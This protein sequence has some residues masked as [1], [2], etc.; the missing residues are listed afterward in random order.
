MC[1]NAEKTLEEEAIE[2]K[3]GLMTNN[4]LAE[5]FGV[6]PRTFTNAKDK[7][8]EELK[9]YA[10]FEVLKGKINILKIKIPVYVK[11]KSKNYLIIKSHID[12]NWNDSGLDNKKNVAE[13]IFNKKEEYHLN[14]KYS[15][16]YSYTCKGSNELYGS[17]RE[18]DKG[19]EIGNCRYVLCTVDVKTGEPRWFTE[20]EYKK[21]I[22]LRKKYFKK[23]NSDEVQ[24]I[25]ETIYLREKRKEITKEDAAA[26][27]Y[28]L[29]RDLYKEYLDELDHYLEG[30]LHYRIY[31]TN[32]INSNSNLI[33]D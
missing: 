32:Y 30:G 22:E 19:G 6:K 13:K 4:E 3:V 8:L 25:K 7:K 5:W 31:K 10:V 14:L 20:E 11:K 16:T 26:A 12:E 18:S 21:K 23:V 24:D 29:E 27:L 2:L 15:T 33:W 17:A 9:E 28:E 1:D